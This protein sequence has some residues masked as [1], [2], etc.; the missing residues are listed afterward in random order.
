MSGVV[1]ER[2]M[3]P[4]PLKTFFDGG[5]LVW[6][7]KDG[8]FKYWLD[9][10]LNLDAAVYNGSENRLHDGVEV[11]RARLGLKT[12]LFKDWLTEIDVDFA[13]NAVEIKDFWPATP[14]STT[15]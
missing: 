7:S 9:G 12:T 3:E 6:A 8:D 10:R 11:R 14:D 1:S 5:Y 2:V 15:A 13:D 4:V